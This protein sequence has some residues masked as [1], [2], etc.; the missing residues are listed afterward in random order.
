MTAI[1][2]R[3]S[4]VSKYWYSRP[5][6]L[7]KARV[8]TSSKSAAR[9]STLSAWD[10]CSTSSH[11]IGTDS[12][13]TAR[14]T[15]TPGA[16]GTPGLRTGSRAITTSLLGTTTDKTLSVDVPSYVG[17]RPLPPNFFQRIYS[18]ARERP[19]QRSIVPA[20]TDTHRVTTVPSGGSGLLHDAKTRPTPT[21]RRSGQPQSRSPARPLGR[22][23]ATGPSALRWH[24]LGRR[25][26]QPTRWAMKPCWLP[27]SSGRGGSS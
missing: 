12:S 22:P 24:G 3:A 13:S 6:K 23:R 26:P 11:C 5:S 18:T 2:Y 25:D 17:P 19:S 16:P 14:F 20:S 27:S 21:P 7:P 15:G 9:R 4:S 10:R 8:L 1:P